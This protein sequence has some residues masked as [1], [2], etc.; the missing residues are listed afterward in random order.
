MAQFFF[1]C[2]VFSAQKRDACKA[3]IQRSLTRSHETPSKYTI[4]TPRDIYGKH[5]LI[6][7]ISCNGNAMRLK[8]VIRTTDDEQ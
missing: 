2:W 7:L 6:V 1:L 5:E 4:Y 8:I 3:D